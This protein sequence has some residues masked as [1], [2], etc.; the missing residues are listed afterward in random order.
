MQQFKGFAF[1]YIIMLR[2]LFLFQFL[3]MASCSS[4]QAVSDLDI[5]KYLGTWYQVYGDDFDKLFQNGKCSTA[6]YSMGEGNTIQV[7]NKELDNNDKQNSISGIAYYKEGDSGGCL[8]VK[9]ENNNPAPYWVL[10]LG[11]IISNQYEY[12]IISDDKALSLFVLTRNVDN[13]YKKYNEDV[14]QIINDMGFD[15][16]WNSPKVMNQTNCAYF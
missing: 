9:L 5:P 7:L 15:K 14:L 11:P 1:L 13:F 10:K 12:S 8:T 2:I 3:L 4:Y 6:E 16:I